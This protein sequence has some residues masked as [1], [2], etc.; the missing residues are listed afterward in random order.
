MT[1][2]AVPS[3]LPQLHAYVDPELKEEVEK[4]AKRRRRTVSSLIAYL[5]Q[6]EV[7]KAKKEGEIQ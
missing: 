4:L 1:T 5:L 2:I 3:K 7:E 6:L